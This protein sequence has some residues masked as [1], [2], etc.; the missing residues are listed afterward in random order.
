MPEDLPLARRGNPTGRCG[1]GNP[2]R[3]KSGPN[4]AFWISKIIKIPGNN[5][6]KKTK[7]ERFDKLLSTKNANFSIALAARAVLMA[8]QAERG[9]KLIK[10]SGKL[11]KNLHFG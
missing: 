9:R 10:S 1:P 2:A 7:I 5:Q 6:R 8:A 4:F 3:S 11:I